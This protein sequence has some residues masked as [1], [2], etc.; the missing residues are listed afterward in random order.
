MVYYKTAKFSLETSE[1]IITDVRD[2]NRYQLKLNT[3]DQDSDPIF[4]D[5]YVTHLKSSQGSDNQNLRLG[6]VTELTTFLESVDPNSYVIFAGDFNLYSSTEPA[7]IELLDETNAI[8][9]V[10]P[11]HTLGA[12]HNNE[13]FQDIHTQST[14]I[15]SGPFGSGAGGGL[16]DRFDFI[17][18]SENMESDPKMRYLDNTYK[19]FGN[20]GNCYNENINNENCTGVYSQEIRENLYNMSDHLPVIM[21]L[22][23]NKEFILSSPEFIASGKISIENTFVSNQLIISVSE[24][25]L[26]NITFTIYNSL[27]QKVLQYD[28]KNENNIIFNISFL[29]SGLFYIKT[30]LPNGAVL[31]FIKR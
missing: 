13:D 14:R 11:I 23:T 1:V 29:Q 15:S 10:D 6:M 4:L 16:D 2:I 28:T 8:V 25:Y 31:K 24:E 7:Y 19:S 3:I 17:T 5:M 9:M 22:E 27:G 18:I 26:E 30:N 12:W 21:K 20:N